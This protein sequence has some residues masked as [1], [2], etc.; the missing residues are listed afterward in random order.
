MTRAPLTATLDG[1]FAVFVYDDAD[2]L[3]L[4]LARSLSYA[5]VPFR[6]VPRI[7]PNTSSKRKKQNEEQEQKEEEQEKKVQT[8]KVQTKKAQTKKAQTKKVQTKKVSTKKGSSK[9]V[10]VK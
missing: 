5:S 6:K 1:I 4:R 2:Q 10:P 7:L 3:L 9:K 8:K